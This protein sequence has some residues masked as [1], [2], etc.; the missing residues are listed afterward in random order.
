MR[1]CLRDDYGFAPI[2][3]DRIRRLLGEMGLEAVYPKKRIP[4]SVPNESHKKYPYL[5]RGLPII[6]QNQVWGTDITYV[7]LE[8]EWAYLVAL[9]DWF[10]R[11]VMSWELSLTMESDFCVAALKGAL[12][13]FVPLITPASLKRVASRSAW[14]GKEDVLITSLPNDYGGR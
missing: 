9:I 5:L 3:R 1:A 13:V 4:T 7:R 2:G 6:R 12:N 8:K 10:S 11:Y 14:T